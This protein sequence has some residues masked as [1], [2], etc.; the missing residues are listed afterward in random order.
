MS[1]NVKRAYRS[2]RRAEAAAQTRRLIRDAAAR[3]FVEQGITATTMRQVAAAAGVAERTVYT[4]FATKTALF[5]EV[6]NIA[7]VGDELPVPVA[8]RAEFTATQ[9]EPDPGRAAEQFADHGC[10]LL[11][12]AG[13]LIIAAVE[14]SGADPDMRQ[15]CEYGAA[16]TAANIRT[17]AQAWHHNGLLRD[18][19]DPDQA[20]AMLYAL[21]SP[22]VHHL[23]RRHQG[24]DPDG[25]RAWLTHTI[26][27]TILRAP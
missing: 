13:D 2:P 24:W 15:F 27:R 21:A 3:L 20:A 12:R 17:V 14:S 11:E 5:H 23:L 16:A 6:I 9:A 1:D 19:L 25:Y 10:A 4:A 7:T 18:E 8:E 26:T 22:Q